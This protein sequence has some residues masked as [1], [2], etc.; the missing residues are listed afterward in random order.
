MKKAV[1]LC[2][3]AMLLTAPQPA[4]AD[5]FVLGTTAFTTSGVFTCAGF[6][7]LACSGS[8]TNTLTLGSGSNTATLTFTGVDTE[9]TVTNR[10]RPVTLGTFTTTGPEDF[11]FPTRR[12]PNVAIIRFDFTLDHSEPIDSAKTTRMS[13][14]PGGGT[15]ARYLTGMGYMRF[16]L[17]SLNL[18]EGANY[19]YMVYDFNIRPF[20]LPG[21]GSIDLTANVGVVPEPATMLL[22]GGGL[23]AALARRRRKQLDG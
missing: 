5:S 19:S 22:V 12:N 4:S 2:C 6:G 17:A 9:L 3:L 14:G 20:A 11:T 8:G 13:F 23:A 21:N 18:P 1:G 10:A 16:S 7:A 15:S